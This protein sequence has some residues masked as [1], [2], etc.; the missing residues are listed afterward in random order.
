M[1]F[2]HMVLQT[3]D[4]GLFLLLSIPVVISSV[5]YRRLSLL[6]IVLDGV[7]VFS[8]LLQ[9]SSCRGLPFRRCLGPGQRSSRI[10][11]S[12]LIVLWVCLFLHLLMAGHPNV[13]CFV[14]LL[15]SILGTCPIPVG[16]SFQSF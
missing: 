7:V 16:F 3:R 13:T 15:L 9:S 1:H 2:R 14:D 12:T 4:C 10:L 5:L 8:G 11:S 6:P